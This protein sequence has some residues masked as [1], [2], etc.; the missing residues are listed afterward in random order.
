MLRRETR[1][2]LRFP[3]VGSSPASVALFFVTDILLWLL[4]Q[5]REHTTSLTRRRPSPPLLP[6]AG[7]APM[8]LL[9]VGRRPYQCPG[10]PRAVAGW[11]C[12]CRRPPPTPSPSSL[13]PAPHPSYTACI[14]REP[15]CA[16]RPELVAA[17]QLRTPVPRLPRSSP[18]SRRRAQRSCRGPPY[19][20][21]LPTRPGIAAVAAARLILPPGGSNATHVPLAP[22]L[23]AA[24]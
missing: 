10:L 9:V 16:A 5:A 2:L 1:N 21:V 7:S 13:A 12:R 6:P 22:S 11:G 20:H 17:R 14:V 23:L 4:R 24:L 15:R 19:P 8:R 3:C 18:H